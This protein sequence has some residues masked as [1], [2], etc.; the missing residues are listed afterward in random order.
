[1]TGAFMDGLIKL[2]DEISADSPC[3][4]YL[5]YDPA[6]LELA[7]NILGKPED[8]ITGESAQPPNWREIQDGSFALLQ[9]S[10]D[11]QL[12]IYLLRA[13]IS[14][15]G[16]TGFQAC[17]KLLYDLLQKYWEPIH[18]LLDPDDDYDPTLRINILEE[19]NN[20]ES[21]LR[22]L[23]LAPLTDSKSVGRFSLR[24]IHLATDSS[25]MAEGVAKPDISVIKAAFLDTPQET[26][27]ATYQAISD[28]LSL[29]QGLDDLVGGKV[30]MENAP[31]LSGLTVLLKEM[32]FA[33]SQYA[34]MESAGTEDA[35]AEE[36]GEAESGVAQAPRKT[37]AV[38]SVGSRQDVLRTLDLIC[39]YYAENEPSSPVPILLQRAKKLVT[40]DF[41][42]IVQ[43]LLPDG[44][45]QLELIKGP[46]PDSSEY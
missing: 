35:G 2:L 18:P 12:V 20:F 46:E 16:V 32:R 30:G 10:K 37:A 33:C 21:V 24:D 7:K 22:P 1:M 5:E 25:E 29:I 3:G 23:S 8:P 28:S 43:N 26:I 40:A 6:Y 44:M 17:L 34:E 19:L 27:T 45:P 9:R 14:L 31:D 39:K 15:E 41:V 4:D 38:G 42:Q 36:G 13:S 11:L